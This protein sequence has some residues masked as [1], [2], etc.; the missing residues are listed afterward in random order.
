MS[1][2]HVVGRTRFV[3]EHRRA[4]AVVGKLFYFQVKPFVFVCFVLYILAPKARVGYPQPAPA[5]A[6]R[7]RKAARVDELLP[8]CALLVHTQKRVLHILVRHIAIVAYFLQDKG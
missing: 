1:R 2:H 4:E 5:V 7:K 8:R 6:Q 3:V